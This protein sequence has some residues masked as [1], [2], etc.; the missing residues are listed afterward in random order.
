M[1]ADRTEMTNLAEKQP[2]KA[3]ELVRKYEEW[4][5]RANVAPWEQVKS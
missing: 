1:E 2:D 3:A 4:A 5:R